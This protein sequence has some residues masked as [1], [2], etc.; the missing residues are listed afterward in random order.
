VF[1]ANESVLLKNCQ[2]AEQVA[3]KQK[4]RFQL[5]SEVA[6]KVGDSHYNRESRFQ[7]GQEAM[8][9]NLKRYQQ[10]LKDKHKNQSMNAN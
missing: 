7:I 2:K 4:K 8:T 9:S 3:K 1:D 10:N 6:K 5:T